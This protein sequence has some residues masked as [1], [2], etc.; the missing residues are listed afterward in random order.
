LMMLEHLGEH[1]HA[2]RIEAALNETLLNKE[3][4]T[5]DLGGKASTTEFTQHIIDKLK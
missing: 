3:Q 5:G 4:C 1:A 2:A